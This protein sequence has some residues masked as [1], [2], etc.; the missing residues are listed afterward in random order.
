MRF[1]DLCE[2]ISIDAAVALWCNVEPGELKSMRFS[3]TCMDAKREAIID[4]LR[5][6][7]LDYDDRP[8]PRSDG[9]GLWYG[10]SID[11]QIDKGVVRINKES[12]RRWFVEMPFTEQPPFLFDEAR[13]QP[14]PNGGEVAEMNTMRALAIMAWILSTNNKALSIGGRPNASEIGNKIEPLVAA[15]FGD[16]ARGFAAF[17]KRISKALKLLEDAHFDDPIPF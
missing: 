11:E 3:T 4:A 6:K 13:R 16:N 15:A 5:G 17:H 9:K 12:M 7:R 14:L 10:A 2:N 1:W 8:V